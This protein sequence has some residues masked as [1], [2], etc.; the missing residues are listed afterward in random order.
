MPRYKVRETFTN[1]VVQNTYIDAANEATA[2][3]ICVSLYGG[4]H[5]VF[6]ESTAV[7]TEDEALAAV[8]FNRASIMIKD[9]STK[10]VAFLNLLVKSDIDIDEIETAL[11]TKTINGVKADSVQLTGFTVVTI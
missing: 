1:D 5:E 3:Q 8:S 4:N 7:T 6:E 11:L 2:L 9:D 10:N